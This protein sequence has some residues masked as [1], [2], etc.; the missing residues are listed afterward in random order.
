[1][2]FEEKVFWQLQSLQEALRMVAQ[3][4]EDVD[5]SCMSA[6]EIIDKLANLDRTSLEEIDARL[7]ELLQPRTGGSLRKGSWGEDLIEIAGT[8]EGLPEDFAQNHD[9]Y[10]HRLE[11]K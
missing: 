5:T 11:T 3:P 8:A 7:H 1:V 4:P 6:R 2:R 10:L 9:F